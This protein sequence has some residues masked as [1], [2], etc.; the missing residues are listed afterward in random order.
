M[1]MN[2]NG[3]VFQSKDPSLERRL[4]ARSFCG[5]PAL[6]FFIGSSG[7]HHCYVRNISGIGSGLRLDNVRLLPMTFLL[8]FDKFDT[9]QM[10]RLRW[11]E[12]DFVG[13][14]FDN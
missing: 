3:D 8:S 12:S 10:C 9:A 2:H 11:R 7:V 4:I 6:I 14:S 1:S 5:K 13:A